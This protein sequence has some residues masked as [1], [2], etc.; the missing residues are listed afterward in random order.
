[1]DGNPI[2]EAH[3]PRCGTVVSYEGTTIETFERCSVRTETP[4]NDGEENA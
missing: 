1:M 2:D 4:Q 3:C